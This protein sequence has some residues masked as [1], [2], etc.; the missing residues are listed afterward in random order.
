MKRGF[1]LIELLVVIAIIGVLSSIVMAS[2]NNARSRANITK[3]KADFRGIETQIELARTG[4]DKTMIGITGSGCS[5]CSGSATTDL[6]WQRLG[7]SSSPK[8]S[9]GS[10]Y[11][12]DENE[13]EFGPS[14]CRK[15]AIFSNGSNKTFEWGGGD[16]YTYYISSWI[17]PQ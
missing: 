11:Q 4:Q 6:S 14:D 10:V 5:V 17:C 13:G 3:V 8:D 15:D 12:M 7:F 1:T 9:W 2:I 16:D